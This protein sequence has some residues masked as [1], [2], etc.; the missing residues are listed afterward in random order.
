M[1]VLM[2]KTPL[3]ERIDRWATSGKAKSIML[4]PSDYYILV[5]AGHL[6][7]I[8]QKYDLEVKCLGGERALREWMK[9][10]T[11]ESEEGE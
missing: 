6:D 1:N 10:K 9:D 3:V 8:K 11:S 4:H 2:L 5:K 7:T